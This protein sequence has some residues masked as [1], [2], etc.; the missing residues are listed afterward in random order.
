MSR[1]YGRNLYIKNDSL[2][3]IELR[4]D[5]IQLSV[6]NESKV[7]NALRREETMV[8][9]DIGHKRGKKGQKFVH[10]P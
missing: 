2:S 5:R 7:M 3:D 10:D 6:Q 1:S 8:V 9:A 4:R